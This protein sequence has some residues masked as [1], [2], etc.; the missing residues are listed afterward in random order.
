MI[1]IGE[2]VAVLVAPMA[3]MPQDMA[4]PLMSV[5]SS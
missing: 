5:T 3:N 2:G 4:G 1:E